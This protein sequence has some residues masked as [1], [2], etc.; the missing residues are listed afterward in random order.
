[1]EMA[2]PWHSP[3]RYIG[4]PSWCSGI[5]VKMINSLVI[6]LFCQVQMLHVCLLIAIYD[7]IAVLLPTP[8]RVE[9]QVTCNSQCRGRLYHPLIYSVVVSQLLHFYS[10]YSLPS[11]QQAP[12]SQARLLIGTYE[13]IRATKVIIGGVDIS[14]FI[15]Y[16]TLLIFRLDL[17][18]IRPHSSVLPFTVTMEM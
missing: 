12:K 17:S 13:D 3:F 18:R 16:I 9:T 8:L 7:V 14:L 2:I 10:H 11:L 5:Y 15:L 6:T 1:M 4:V